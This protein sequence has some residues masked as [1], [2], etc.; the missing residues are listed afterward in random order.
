MMTKFN[1][2]MY[3]KLRA[4]PLFSISQKRPLVTKEVVKTTASILVASDPKAASPAVSIEEI[5]P[6]PK[7]ARENNKG[8]SKMDSNIW[9]DAATAMGRTYNIVTPNELK[10]LSAIPSHNLVSRHVHKLVQ[11]RPL[12]E[13]ALISVFF[14]SRNNPYLFFLKF[15]LLG[16]VRD[17][18][19]Y[20]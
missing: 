17:V 16:F 19:H 2:E 14:V 6:R 9:D 10:G 15:F 13:L 3:A 4:R 12:P 8:K 1:Q 18:P 11:V 5:T 7:E 20:H